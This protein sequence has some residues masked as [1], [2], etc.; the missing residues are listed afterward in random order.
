MYKDGRAMDHI[1]L[2]RESDLMLLCPATA[3]TINKLAAGIA[4][5]MIGA[6]F[7]ANNFKTPYWVVPAMNSEM[8]KHPATAN[9]LA[10]L[11]KWGARIFETAEGRLACGE[12]GQG[13][14]LEPSAIFEEIQRFFMGNKL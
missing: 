12:F 3:N 10:T 9:S 2:A 6:L 7:L 5:D 1:S 14:M 4:E 13:K 11:E 8:F